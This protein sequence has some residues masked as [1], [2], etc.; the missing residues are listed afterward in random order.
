MRAVAS[1]LALILVAALLN[2]FG[3]V[4][5][6]AAPQALGLVLTET[7][8]PLKCGVGGCQAEFS[9]F[10]LQ[11]DRFSPVSGTR[12]ELIST[13]SITL[14]GRKLDGGVVALDAAKHLAF[15]AARSHVAMRISIPPETLVRLG[16]DRVTVAVKANAALLPLGGDKEVDEWGEGMRSLVAGPLR[17]LGAQLVDHNTDRMRAARFTNRIINALP[18]DRA[19]DP[20]DVRNLLRQPGADFDPG[21]LAPEARRFARNAIELCSF[22]VGSDSHSNMRRCLQHQ[23]DNLIN[24]LNSRY[25]TA[26]KTGS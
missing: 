22:A 13:D 21:Q 15:E 5:V 6:Q 24:F 16:L 19:S 1:W 14:S 26:V 9:A 18:A 8:V 12:Y 7:E 17:T 10:C 25:W 4:S 20:E 23:H 11:P 3:T 2:V